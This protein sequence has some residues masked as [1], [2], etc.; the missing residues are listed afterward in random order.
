M[1]REKLRKEEE[2]RTGISELHTGDFVTGG[3]HS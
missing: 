1:G 2:R 3:H